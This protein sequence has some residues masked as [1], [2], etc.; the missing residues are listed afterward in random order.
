MIVRWLGVGSSFVVYLLDVAYA[1][2]DIRGVFV[3]RSLCINFALI[4]TLAGEAL[5]VR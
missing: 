2:I 5:E 1:L 4:G 3:L